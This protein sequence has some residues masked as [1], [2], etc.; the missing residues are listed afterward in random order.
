[1]RAQCGRAWSAIGDVTTTML[2]D[3]R[4]D[5]DRFAII[6]GVFLASL[7]QPRGF[8]WPPWPIS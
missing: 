4:T 3:R 5:H 7:I 1:L 2:L 6:K 8:L